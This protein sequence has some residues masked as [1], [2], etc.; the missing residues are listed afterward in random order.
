MLL[1]ASP[2]RLKVGTTTYI[3]PPPAKGGLSL[4]FVQKATT[5]ENLSGAELTRKLGY[6][7]VVTAKWPLYLPSKYPQYAG[8][9]PSIEE[10]LTIL[11]GPNKSYSVSPGLTTGGFLV[12]SST[13]K[14]LGVAGP[15]ITGLEVTFRG[16]T[17][18]PMALDPLEFW[19]P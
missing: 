13:V 3:L 8:Q 10:L 16:A 9:M 7:P 11:S 17:I 15:Y 12:D 5:R 6:V 4:E 1:Q 18:G 19:T 2:I 14:A